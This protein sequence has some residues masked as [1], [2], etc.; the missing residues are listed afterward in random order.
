MQISSDPAHVTKMYVEN[1]TLSIRKKLHDTYSVNKYGWS[2]WVFDQYYLQPSMKI[3]ELGCGTGTFWHENL[4]RL[5]ENLD[6]TL[7]DFSPLMLDKTRNLLGGNPRFTFAN[8]DIQDIR[9]DDCSFDLVIANHMLYH[10][11]DID[12]AVSEAYRVLKPDGYFFA[13]TNGE[14]TMRELH[15]VYRRLDGKIKFSYAGNMPFTLENGGALL[16]KCFSKVEKR[17]YIDALEVTEIDDLVAYVTS[18]NDVPKEHY[19]ELYELIREG[20]GND[21]VFRISKQSGMFI[22]VK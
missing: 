4:N 21:G 1:D 15:D 8:A 5:P 10:V 12:K 9:F 13:A 11:P 16:G 17:L 20:F 14:N 7:S 6:I 3:F 2:R 22:C 19:G 18:Y